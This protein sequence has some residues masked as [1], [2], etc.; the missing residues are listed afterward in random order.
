VR[1]WPLLGL[2]LSVPGGTLAGMYEA[3]VFV[4]VR[5]VPPELQPGAVMLAL[6]DLPMPWAETL[7]RSEQEIIGLLT[8]FYAT[9]ADGLELSGLSGGCTAG[10]REAWAREQAQRTWAFYCPRVLPESD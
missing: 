4:I 9:K 2:V 7:G 8:K 5:S 10:A 3:K 1:D 6:T